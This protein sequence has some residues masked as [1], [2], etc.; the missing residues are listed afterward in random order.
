MMQGRINSGELAVCASQSKAPYML[1]ANVC[2]AQCAVRASQNEAPYMLENFIAGGWQAV[3][4]SQNEAPYMPSVLKS[5]MGRLYVPLKMK[6][7]T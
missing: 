3:R 2:R 7:H 4:A 1:T 6:P 5:M